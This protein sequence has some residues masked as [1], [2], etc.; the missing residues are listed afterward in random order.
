M[1]FSLQMLWKMLGTIQYMVHM[2]LMAIGFP[3]NASFAFSFIID[4]ANLKIINVDFIIENVFGI[5]K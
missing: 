4:L 5:E 2:P 1:G 3:A